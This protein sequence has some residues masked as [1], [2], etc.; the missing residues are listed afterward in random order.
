MGVLKRAKRHLKEEVDDAAAFAA[1]EARRPVL[2]GSFSGSRNPRGDS[3]EPGQ[4]SRRQAA[5]AAEEA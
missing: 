1:S 5:K 4:E 3:T 2:R